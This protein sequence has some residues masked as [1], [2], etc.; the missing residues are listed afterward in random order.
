[1]LNHDELLAR[2]LHDRLVAIIRL[3]HDAPLVRVAEALVAGGI[4]ALDV[5]NTR[6]C[7]D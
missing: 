5:L 2:M 4:R 1:M 3:R 6:T 7:C